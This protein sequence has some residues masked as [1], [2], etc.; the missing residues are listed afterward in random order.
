L[1]R[2]TRR[3]PPAV[4]GEEVLISMRTEFRGAGDGKM[5]TKAIS[6]QTSD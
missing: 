6:N 4:R 5:R 1:A 2:F 3:K